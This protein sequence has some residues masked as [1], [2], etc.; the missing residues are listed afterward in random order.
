M[1]AYYVE[2]TGSFSLPFII[3]EWDKLASGDT[4]SVS[5]ATLVIGETL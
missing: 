4:S 2:L 1:I 3:S 5:D